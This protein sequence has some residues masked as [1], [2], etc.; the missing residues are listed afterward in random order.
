MLHTEDILSLSHK[1]GH[2]GHWFLRLRDRT[3]FW[4]PEMFSLHGLTRDA[5][6]PTLDSA[7]ACYHPDDCDRVRALVDETLET[8]NSLSYEARIVRPDGTMLWAEVRGE[9]KASPNSDTRYL[10]GIFRDISENQEQRIHYQRLAW[11]IE[12]TEEA[13]MKRRTMAATRRNNEK[14][15]NR[16]PQAACH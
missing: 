5:P 2:S 7:L 8:G 6:Q 13:I 12:N 15:A 11:V 9:I 16:W 4:S 3:L 10:F 14:C 1:I